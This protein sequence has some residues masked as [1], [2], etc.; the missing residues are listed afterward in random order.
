[1]KLTEHHRDSVAHRARLILEAELPGGRDTRIGR[2]SPPVSPARCPSRVAIPEDHMLAFGRRARIISTVGEV[3][4]RE[5][6]RTAGR[7]TAVADAG[8]AAL[9]PPK[10]SG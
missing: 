2:A 4:V 5:G 9:A 1:M 3:A 8:R 7:V 6:P 10:G